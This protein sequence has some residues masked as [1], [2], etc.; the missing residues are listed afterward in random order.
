MKLGTVASVANIA[1][2]KRVFTDPLQT[3]SIFGW[4]DG[5]VVCGASLSR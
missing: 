3:P 1:K 2:K 4:I 5:L